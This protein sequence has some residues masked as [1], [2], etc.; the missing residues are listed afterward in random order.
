MIVTSLP[1]SNYPFKLFV[2]LNY[3]HMA[4]LTQVDVLQITAP[5]LVY[6]MTPKAITL[7]TRQQEGE[8]FA[9]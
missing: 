5:I 9:R 4:P 7:I 3:S 8:S 6:S 2:H 1:L